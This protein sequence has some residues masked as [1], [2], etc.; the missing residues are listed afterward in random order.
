MKK[1]FESEKSTLYDIKDDEERTKKA[2][3]LKKKGVKI[4]VL[5]K[6]SSCIIA[7]DLYNL[8][9]KRI[10]I[11]GGGRTIWNFIKDNCFDEIRI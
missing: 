1:E 5:E 11:E 4:R 10:L 2:N 7:E 8:G 3:E 9:V 6:L